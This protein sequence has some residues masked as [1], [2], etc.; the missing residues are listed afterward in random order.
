MRHL[1]LF[2]GIGGFA[3]AADW[4]WPG[5]VEHIFCEIEPFCQKV[6]KK[7]WPEAV[8][9]NDIKTLDGKQ[10]AGTVD[11][12]TGGFPCQ[13]F[14][15]AGNRKGNDDDR[16]LWPAMLRVIDECRPA[17]IIGENVAGI[18]DMALKQIVSDLGNIGYQCQPILIPACAIDAPHRRDRVWFCAH[19]NSKRL[20]RW[21]KI[22][23]E[24]ESNKQLQ[25]LLQANSWP[26]ISKRIA[27]GVVD[28]VSRKL[29]SLR[30]HALGN[31]I[32]PGIAAVIMQAIKE[33]DNA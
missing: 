1:D 28:G 15:V 18:I 5:Q 21:A 25:R 3:L 31:A 8:I 32:Y 4:V 9:H 10:Y 6:L 24:T 11:I 29:D 20:P 12:I 23:L 27:N 7:H 16:F 13:P 2:S 33:V 30:L 19:S 14:S 17:W 22:S 26:E